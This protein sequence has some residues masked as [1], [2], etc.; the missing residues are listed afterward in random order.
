MPASQG[1]SMEVDYDIYA[2]GESLLGWV[3]ATVSLSGTNWDGNNFLAAYLT[4]VQTR[5]SGSGIEI[6]HLKMTLSPS[7]GHDLGVMNLVRTESQGELSHALQEPLDSGELI[8]N[9]R[10][11][12]DPEVLMNVVTEALETIVVQYGIQS[13]IQHAE[14]FRPGRPVPT[15]RDA[16]G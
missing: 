2:E 5:L 10:A 12:A 3:N 7:E 14:A 4:E 13:S 11:E 1:E 6:A 16:R 9:L 15:H 8:V